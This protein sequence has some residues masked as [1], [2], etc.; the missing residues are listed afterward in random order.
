[1][2]QD[3]ALQQPLNQLP[4]LYQ[5]WSTLQ[6]VQSLLSLADAAGYLVTQQHICR[7]QAGGTLLQVLPTQFP[8]V[9]LQHPQ[10]GRTVQVWVEHSYSTTQRNGFTSMSRLQRP[11]I[12]LEVLTAD[13]LPC[14]YVFDPK[15]R[16]DNAAHT[17]P[18]KADLDRMHAYRDA[19]RY[20]QQRVVAY[21]AILYPGPLYSY[22]KQEVEALPA[23]PNAI[24]ALQTALQPVLQRVLGT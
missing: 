15:Y 24:T 23:R 3:T 17:Q 11:D 5:M 2:L 22:G 6:L 19:I 4:Y 12:V 18:S 7:P 8:I 20:Q 1:V 10:Q 14:L 16:L 13:A 21:A 9:Q